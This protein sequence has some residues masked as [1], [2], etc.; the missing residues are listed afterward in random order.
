MDGLGEQ[1]PWGRKWAAILLAIWFMLGT[2]PIFV[3]MFGNDFVPSIEWVLKSEIIGIVAGIIGAALMPSIVL[4]G[5]RKPPKIDGKVKK[6][7]AVIFAPLFGYLLGNTVVVVSVPMMLALI[8]GHQIELIFTV[9]SGD[10]GGS[11]KCRSPL[12]LQE[13]PLLF[14]EICGVPE[15]FRQ[16]LVPGQKIVL[17]GRGTDFGIFVQRLRKVD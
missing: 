10:R 4:A 15:D 17:I 8:P 7:S 5:M 12:E 1:Q 14:D 2:L 16:G 3:K 9:E 6:A 11:R 13:L